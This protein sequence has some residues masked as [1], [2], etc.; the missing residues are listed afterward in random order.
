M[1]KLLFLLLVSVPLLLVLAL[2]NNMTHTNAA[3]PIA[4]NMTTYKDPQGRFTVSYPT[5]WTSTPASNRFESPLVKFESGVG[6]NV[7]VAIE[8]GTDPEALSRELANAG[9]FGY[10][11]FQDVECTKYKVD[12]QKACSLIFTKEADPD[13]GTQ[14]VV[15]M[16]VLSYVN[17][18]LYL[19]G[20]G[21]TQNT[22]DSAL[23]TYE[24][25]LTSFN[26]G[27]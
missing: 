4:A 6:P 1:N 3:T 26:A 5:N 22:F 25:M 8:I 14:G 7:Q 11:L 9:L 18:H 17:G 21:A 27:K 15:V 19:I 23:P 20:Y 10:T 12:G 13:L 16:S 2:S 24:A